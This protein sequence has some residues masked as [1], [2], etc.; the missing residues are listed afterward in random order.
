M[1]FAELWQG[2]VR[3]RDGDGLRVNGHTFDALQCFQCVACVGRDG[4]TLVVD[5]DALNFTE[6]LLC[7]FAQLTVDGEHCL[8]VLWQYAQCKVLDVLVFLLLLLEFSHL[9]TYLALTVGI[10]GQS[11]FQQLVDFRLYL[12]FFVEVLGGITTIATVAHQLA[13]S[14]S[15]GTIHSAIGLALH[16]VCLACL[17]VALLDET[18]KVI[19]AVLTHLVNAEG[20]PLFELG[21]GV[22]FVEVHIATATL[23]GKLGAGLLVPLLVLLVALHLLAELFPSVGS[24]LELLKA[25]S[26]LLGYAV[27]V[28]IDGLAGLLDLVANQLYNVLYTVLQLLLQSA[29]LSGCQLVAVLHLAAIED[30]IPTTINGCDIATR[31]DHRADAF[32]L[33]LLCAYLRGLNGL[34]RTQRIE[35]VVGCACCLDN[36]IHSAEKS[37]DVAIV[38]G[39]QEALIYALC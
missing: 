4:D 22:V 37:A 20:A 11:L 25:H 6:I 5:G 30:G 34:H 28:G 2:F 39:C 8:L 9:L 21:K 15:F 26:V 13:N 33:R 7:L 38:D 3:C 27:V 17:L 14:E 36:I 1:N 23:L 19:V 24:L 35:L 31:L 12:L 32:V 18:Y 10:S 29:N 16:A